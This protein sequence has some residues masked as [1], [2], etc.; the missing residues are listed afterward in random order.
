M[1]R[2]LW[3]A[4]SGMKAQQ[5]NLDVIANNLANVNTTGFKKQRA[6]FEDL[7]YQTEREPGV[8][9]EPGSAVPVGVQVGLGSKVVGTGR[10]MT[11]G[12]V[13][14]TDNPTDL[15]IQGDGYFQVIVPNGEIAYTRSG[16]FS[17]DGDGQ[18]VTMDGYLLEPS[19]VIPDDATEITVSD[20]GLVSVKVPGDALLQEIG[21]IEL[22]R[23]VNPAGLSA[24]GNS[25]FMETDASGAPIA[26]MPAEEGMGS[27]VQGSLEM[28]NVQVVEEMVSMITAQR[29]YE[30]GSKAVQTADD[31]L[32]IANSMKK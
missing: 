4:A 26:G 19:I 3:S 9:V 2:S 1:I 30:A 16:A 13:Q 27:M 23:F 32:A 22:A 18:M 10:I 14:V 17:V 20:T 24:S 11:Q 12:T 7:M 15:M 8:P 21:Q 31:L 5:T 28:S 25:L 6:D 29:A